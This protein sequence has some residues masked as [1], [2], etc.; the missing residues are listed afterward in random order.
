MVDENEVVEA[1]PEAP[2]EELPAENIEPIEE[3]AAESE[4][5]KQVDLLEDELPAVDAMR[6]ALMAEGKESFS[7]TPEQVEALP[8]DAKRAIYNFRQA[9]QGKTR[10]LAEM[11]G[12]LREEQRQLAD[13]KLRL[14]EE[15]AK[16]YSGML[17]LAEMFKQPEMPDGG[18]PDPFTPEGRKWHARRDV[19]ELMGPFFEK[20]QEVSDTG[21]REV[22]EAIEQAAAA[23]EQARVD[24]EVTK[25]KAWIDDGENKAWWDQNKTY[26]KAHVD[27]GLNWDKAIEKVKAH[28]G[29]PKEDPVEQERQAAR[30]ISRRLSSVGSPQRKPGPKLRQNM[31]YTGKPV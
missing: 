7:I 4:A 13:M 15:R 24:A 19:A 2:V 28:F 21:I 5:P 30:R 3:A 31:S 11:R 20:L 26:V 18:E 10:E 27:Q 23:K 16:L 8:H 9:F 29:P 22:N 12:T 1:T 6:A 14:D 17:P 25:L